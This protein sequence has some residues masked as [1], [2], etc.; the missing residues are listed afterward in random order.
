MCARMKSSQSSKVSKWLQKSMHI[1]SKTYI[2]R[3]SW[4]TCLEKKR[5]K[6]ELT[7]R[8][9]A[10]AK[11]F[12][13]AR[14]IHKGGG[15]RYER[16][17]RRIDSDL[18]PGR[19]RGFGQRKGSRRVVP[20][21]AFCLLPSIQARIFSLSLSLSLPSFRSAA[22]GRGATTDASSSS[23]SSNI[24]FLF[25][26]SRSHKEEVHLHT[27]ALLPLLLCR[28]AADKEEEEEE[29]SFS[30]LQNENEA[31][32]DGGKRGGGRVFF[33]KHTAAVC[34]YAPAC[35]GRA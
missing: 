6:P 33:E 26:S 23:S 34:P 9:Y 27:H 32:R 3:C 4:C 31:E 15:G 20:I 1:S 30:I 2:R 8:A 35:R 25:R 24:L 18:K 19:Y 11:S 22:D 7:M 13:L 12:A 17:R 10:H 5:R 21:R 14:L 28:G 16:S 29:A